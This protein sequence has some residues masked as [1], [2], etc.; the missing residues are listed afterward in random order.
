MPLLG[1]ACPEPLLQDGYQDVA[2]L[3]TQRIGRETLVGSQVVPVGQR[4]QPL[5][6]PVEEILLKSDGP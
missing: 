2:M 3:N 6:L 5:P 4:A 1:S